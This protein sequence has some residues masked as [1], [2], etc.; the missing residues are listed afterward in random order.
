MTLLVHVYQ[1]QWI[2]IK[3]YVCSIW[4][5]RNKFKINKLI[6]LNIINTQY[7]VQKLSIYFAK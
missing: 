7:P 4:W 2:I 3:H 1:K 6:N 5:Q